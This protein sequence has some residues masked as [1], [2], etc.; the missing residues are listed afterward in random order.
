[1]LAERLQT[2]LGGLDNALDKAFHIILFLLVYLNVHHVSGN[3]KVHENHHSVHVRESLALG[4]HGF[5]GHILQHQVYAFSAHLFKKMPTGD[6]IA[7]G[8]LT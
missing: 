7:I 3:G 2:V 4:G 8:K 6:S 5:D 1:M